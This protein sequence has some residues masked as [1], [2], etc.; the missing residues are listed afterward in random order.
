VSARTIDL[1]DCDH[2]IFSYGVGATNAHRQLVSCISSRCSR[3][4]P[5]PS[6]HGREYWPRD[7]VN[8]SCFS[9]MTTVEIEDLPAIKRVIGRRHP[10]SEKTQIRSYAELRS[11]EV[12]RCGCNSRQRRSQLCQRAQ[13]RLLATRGLLPLSRTAAAAKSGAGL[14]SKPVLLEIVEA[15]LRPFKRRPK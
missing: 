5:R 10:M 14:R 2:A 12:D 3:S 8:R 9:I 15:H 13:R 7:S 6:E 1:R 11:T 4:I